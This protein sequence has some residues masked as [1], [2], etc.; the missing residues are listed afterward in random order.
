[1]EK[2]HPAAIV[3]YSDSCA[4]YKIEISGKMINGVM[5]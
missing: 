4:G 5:G 1:M 3:T 2:S